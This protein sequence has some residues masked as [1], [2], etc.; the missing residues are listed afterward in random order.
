MKNH[1]VRTGTSY[2]VDYIKRKPP[3]QHKLANI[4]LCK[5]AQSRKLDRRRG[6]NGRASST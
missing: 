3:L 2:G 4:N 6:N 1:S 5:A